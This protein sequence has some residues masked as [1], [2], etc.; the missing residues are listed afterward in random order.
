[1]RQVAPQK[2]NTSIAARMDTNVRE[3]L[4]PSIAQGAVYLG[5][6]WEDHILPEIEAPSVEDTPVNWQETQVH[7]QGTRHVLGPS[8]YYVP[9]SSRARWTMGGKGKEGVESPYEG[10]LELP[11]AV[12]LLMMWVAGVAL[13]GLCGL[14]VY[15]VGRLLIGL[16]A[17]SI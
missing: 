7:W 8:G 16:I 4:S 3:G 2:S 1:M 15:W 13:L 5:D 6:L 11:P 14:V 10:F 12:V 9:D 17:G